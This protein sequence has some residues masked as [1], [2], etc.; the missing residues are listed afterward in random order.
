[1]RAG[2]LGRRLGPS[3]RSCIPSCTRAWSCASSLERH[4]LRRSCGSD[5]RSAVRDRLSRH[6]EL[7]DEMTN[8]LRLDLDRHEFLPVVDRD[9]LSD[10]V[11]KDRHVPAMCPDRD[12]G[13][14]RAEFFDETVSLVMVIL[15]LRKQR[16]YCMLLLV[17]TTCRF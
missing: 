10:E 8:H 3:S 2:G 15:Y 13:P 11:G 1:M 5:A 7:T 6:R 16:L 4:E 17:C 12:L 14:V 9:L